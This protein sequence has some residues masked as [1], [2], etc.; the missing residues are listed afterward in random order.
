V[1]DPTPQ[2]LAA[3][4]ARGTSVV[5]SSGAGCGK[6]FVLTNRYLSHLM[7]DGV[8]VGE[9]VA[10][11]FTDRAAREMRDRIRKAVTAELQANRTDP[12]W[13]T[14][15][16]DLESA[17]VQTIHSFCGDLLRQFAVAA[18]LDPRFEVLEEIL[19]ENL[20]AE[21]L[22]DTLQALLTADTPAGRDL[23]ELVVLYGWTTTVTAVQALLRE[24][25]AA[26]WTAWLKRTPQQ[27]A[28]EWSGP[29]RDALLPIWVD[30]LCAASP[31]IA[32]LTNLFRSI[33]CR[34]PQMRANV[35]TVLD[36]LPKL[37]SAPDLA[38]AVEEL[39]E[40][41]K[42][43]K[44]KAKAW[45]DDATYQAVKDAM[46]DFRAD[47]PDKLALFLE[48][49]DGVEEVARVGQRFLRV[50]LS[51][52]EVYQ[53]RKVRAG[54]VDFQDLLVL[55]RDLLRDRADVR[56]A[57]QQRFRYLLL[58]E[59][60]DTDPVQMELVELLC[61][62]GIEHDKL[63]AVGDSKQSI[64]R[65]RGAEVAL[66]EKLRAAV[67]A[68]GRLQ[69]TRNYRSQPGIL[70]FVN[71]L[72]A[73]RFP[74]YEPLDNHHPPASEE[75]CVEFLWS[76]PASG[77]DL[78]K[79]SVSGQ[80]A[81]EAD[82]IARRIAELIADPELRVRDGDGQRRVAPGDVVLLFR[83]MSNV[84][85]YEAALR[86]HGL[87]YYL[88]GGRAFFAQ[89]EVYDLL[90]VLRTLENPDDSI[91]LAGTLRSPF[92][93]LSD[94]ALLLL[95][96]HP[97]GLWAGLH[98]PACRA[99]LPVEQRP[100]AE[101]ICQLLD[102]WR[103]LKD[104]LPIARLIGR[105]VADTG[106]D[107]ALQFEFLGDRKLANLWKLIDLARA[108]DRPGL[109]G[110]PEFIARLGELVNTQPRE[111]QAATQP[112]NADVVRIMSI[113]Q[114]KGLEFPVVFVPDLAARGLGGRPAMARWDR[115]LGCIARPP[116]EDP[117]LFTDYPYRLAQA[118]EA[119]A[120]WR[121]DLRILYV[122][123]TRA[124]DLLVLSA[125]LAERF[126]VDTPPDRPVPVKAANTWMLAL[127]ERFHL[128]SGECLDPAVLGSEQ[129][130]VRIRLVEPSAAPP[131]AARREG[132]PAHE[133]PAGD[134]QPVEPLPRP[135]IVDLSD[136]EQSIP[137]ARFREV[138]SRWELTGPV[139]S[140][141]DPET[142]ALLARFAGSNWPNRLQAADR[143]FRDLEF[144]AP[145]PGG[146]ANAI[147]GTIDFLWREADGWHVLALDAG[148]GRT[149]EGQVVEGW[150]V[151]E[152]FGAPPASVT[153]L[154]LRTGTETRVDPGPPPWPE[155]ASGFP[156]LSVGLTDMR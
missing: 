144:L 89:Q 71:A 33:E 57:I 62:V 146:P 154:D 26:A 90:N 28:A 77:G 84:G 108:F 1:P 40:A 104:R 69:L 34:G 150:V 129:P 54:V 39:C 49:P 99:G 87:D 53:H 32:H 9:I 14:H 30:H 56:E 110:L 2:Q 118:S 80:R 67:R 124:R 136:L 145:W 105:V 101:R 7:Q 78:G 148:E 61:G 116:S 95:A 147:R 139:P 109:F 107:A 15:L 155:L 79:E 5:L 112:E 36:G 45:P 142:A 135:A 134:F 13:A 72:C 115:R 94:D 130:R 64:Y 127:G 113:H 23:A 76:V 85:I 86:R 97:D 153:L 46:S 82:T 103:P 42:V 12:S 65:F 119:I 22:R 37:A 133:V 4:A 132:E 114:A 93:C 41:A 143:L 16:R 25:D 91:A 122:A 47:L 81:R 58:D 17:P 20:R 63:F 51:V 50:A 149:P 38:A 156:R 98:D 128:A 88:V 55:A 100:R 117:P 111:E 120:D 48:E 24:R 75:A 151:Q 74:A 27:I 3:I 138:L 121:E 60:Q 123:C 59:M 83:S 102:T 141:A 131:R 19:S 52:V 6:T 43:G 125:G 21:A 18:G 10:I 126:P 96:I 140:E 8:R 73:L 31:K 106:Y 152:Q 35:R 66:F 44:E 137:A 11:T 92:G 29:E 70:H 68:E